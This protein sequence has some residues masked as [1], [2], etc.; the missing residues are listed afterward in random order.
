MKKG[1]Y[2][3]MLTNKNKTVLYTGVTNNIK[4][5]IYQ[6]KFEKG[7]KFT[8]RYNV[9]ILVYYEWLPTIVEAIAREKAIKGISRAK[10][11]ALIKNFNPEWLDLYDKVLDEE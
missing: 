9:N 8:S 5:R 7:S 4:R 1:G 11:E 10:K 6:H 2:A 3:Y